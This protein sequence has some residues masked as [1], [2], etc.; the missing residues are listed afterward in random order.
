MII[1]LIGLLLLSAIFS[2]L[3]IGMFSLN[4]DSLA[5]KAR[6]G[7]A[8]AAKVLT[9][10]K[11]GNKLLCTLLLSNTAIN[12]VV[13][14][15]L[16][17][18]VSGY[19]AAISSTI[20]IFLFGELLPQAIFSKYP[21][22]IGSRTTWLVKIFMFIL[23]P[24]TI[25]ISFILNKVLGEDF[26]DRYD[27]NELTLLLEDHN[28]SSGGPLDADE[29]R[30]LRSTL[31]FSDK[32]AEQILTPINMVFR[33]QENVVLN[34]QELQKIKEENYSRIPV[35]ADTRDD[36]IGV[37][38][39]K[40]LIGY[41]PKSNKLVGELCVKDKVLFVRED[42]KLDKLLNLLID[43]K[44]HLAFVYNEHNVL[45]GLTSLEDV[46]EEVIGKQIMD[47]SDTHADLQ[48]LA[49]QKQINNIVGNHD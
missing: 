3:T 42:I 8:M 30:I 24:V 23:S 20:F 5:R 40:N 46:L 28:D 26:P 35:Y 47:E 38:F 43:K 37:L 12:S 11:K 33:L 21:L 29:G 7:N 14:I 10:R 34:E 44:I 13:S 49:K 15:V 45:T 25:P 6:N 19:I 36:I 17:G 31:T 9:I 4:P 18:M 32:T 41:D 39:A 27:R 48:H 16:G 2:G 1:A 22:E